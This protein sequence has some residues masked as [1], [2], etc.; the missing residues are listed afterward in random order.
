MLRN[1]EHRPCFRITDPFRNSL[2]RRP[3]AP[4]PHPRCRERHRGR[5]ETGESLIIR[6]L[7]VGG[8][9]GPIRFARASLIAVW[10][11][12]ACIYP[13]SK[14]EDVSILPGPDGISASSPNQVNGL[15]RPCPPQVLKKLVSPLSPSRLAQASRL[16]HL[17]RATESRQ[18]A[19]TFVA[20][21]SGTR[22]CVHFCWRVRRKLLLFQVSV[23]CR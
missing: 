8:I 18:R 11:R 14:W 6:G 12:D 15:G 22:E 17:N 9:Y 23:V 3:L 19:D 2:K 13:A 10:E 7:K 21:L 4:H 16:G 5:T 1:S 20:S